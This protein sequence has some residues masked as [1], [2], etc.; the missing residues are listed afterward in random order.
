MVIQMVETSFEHEAALAPVVE[1]KGIPKILA[2]AAFQGPW[3]S[4]QTQHSGWPAL[5]AASRLFTLLSCQ[6]INV[7]LASYDKLDVSF[8]SNQT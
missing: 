3:P 4:L 2:S 5:V 8:A 6:V 1:A 7:L